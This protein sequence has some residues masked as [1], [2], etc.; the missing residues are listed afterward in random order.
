MLL[1]FVRTVNAWLSDFIL[2]LFPLAVGIF[3]SVQTRFVQIRAFREGLQRVLSAR[4]NPPSRTRRPRSWES[5]TWIP[6]PCTGRWG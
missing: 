5:F 3:F 2:I 4:E 1:Q 6:A